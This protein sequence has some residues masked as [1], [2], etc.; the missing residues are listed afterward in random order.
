MITSASQRKSRYL[1]NDLGKR[2]S[3]GIG[4]IVIPPDI[5]RNEYV[6]K[7]VASGMVAVLFDDGGYIE[8]A[9]VAKHV[10][11]DIVFP[12]NKSGLGSQISWVSLNSS[13]Q[14]LVI[15]VHLKYN[16]YSQVGENQSSVVR[17][18]KK[19]YAECGVDGDNLNV[20]IVSNSKVGN[21]SEV[22][23]SA[24]SSE[25]NSA[26]NLN[27]KGNINLKASSDVNISCEDTFTLKVADKSVDDK[28]TTLKY[29]KGQGLSYLD[30]FDNEINIGEGSVDIKAATSV[31]L[32]EGSEPMVLGDKLTGI[33]GDILDAIGQITVTAPT[34]GGPTTIPINVASFQAIKAQLETVLSQ[35]AN[36][37]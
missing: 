27:C 29:I 12:E 3:A 28:V 33:L 17:Q 30:E 19:G 14:I 10:L 23:I 37:D 22:N 24:S 9:L 32:G 26:I 21:P 6:R 20:S 36:T 4:Y 35:Y 31:N 13:N 15:G 5:D 25:G 2:A 16:E 11:N 7:S 34:S 8:Q 18:T 1:V